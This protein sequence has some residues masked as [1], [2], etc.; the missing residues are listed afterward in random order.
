MGAPDVMLDAVANAH[1]VV[2]RCFADGFR[3]PL[4]LGVS[5]WADQFR[6]L[7]SKSS[8]EPGRWRTSRVPY[9]R[10][11]M[12]CLDPEH[13]AR[14]IVFKKPVQAGGTEAGNNW[15]G[16]IMQTRKA[17][18]MVVQ[19]TLDLAE[20]WSKQRLAP[21]IDDTPELKRI[22]RPAR[23][24]DSGNT[25]LLKDFPGGVL[26]VAGANSAAGLC[27]KPVRYL[28]LDEVDRYP[29]N[30]ENEGD[31]VELAE[32]RTTAFPRYKIFVLSTPTIESLSRIHK[33]YEASDQRRYYVPCPHCEHYQIL[34]WANLTWTAGRPED[35]RYICEECGALIDERHKEEMLE[36]GI[37]RAT[38]PDRKI[39]GFHINALYTPIGLG[40]S[41]EALADQFEKAGKDPIKH[42]AFINL[43]LGECT[44]D[45]NEKLDS[46]EISSRAEPRAVRTIP[47]GCLLLTAGVDVQK[48][49]WAVIIL[50]WGRGSLVWVI[51]YFELPGNPTVPED[52]LALEKRVM[53][54]ITNAYGIPMKVEQVAV[55]S[56]YLQ[57][58]VIHFT[59]ARQ[60]RGWFAVKGAKEANRPIITRPSR[61]DYSW[62]GRILKLGAE[63]WQVGGFATKE[64]LFARLSGDRQLL[65]EDR[66]VRFPAELGDVFYEQLTAEVFDDVLRRFVKIRERNEVLDVFCYAI[67]AAWHP[68]I[69]VQTWQESRWLQREQLM[70]PVIT[71]LFAPVALATV[72]ET[73][74]SAACSVDE[75]IRRARQK[76]QQSRT[77]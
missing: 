22:I 71:D 58:D 5:D 4:R 10:E 20:A 38:Y 34:V 44:K 30:I 64:W 45:P 51:D 8:A 14:R 53:E 57:D 6:R 18:M 27:S 73:P 36:A 24:R 47:K 61:I 54:P 40:K 11:I 60:R 46:D 31:P 29:L 56:G 39:V 75:M 37:W 28:M 62:R 55:D 49:R 33:E 42:K 67:A 70:E 9:L 76:V 1:K 69:R 35:A 3:A 23:E 26:I 59:R 13:P 65:P 77:R 43:R 63:Q 68:L 15:V 19:P 66:L 25:T 16:C 2:W 72:T 74:P 50:G 41:W 12:D 17:P 48:D 52:W 7:S 21:M 32:G